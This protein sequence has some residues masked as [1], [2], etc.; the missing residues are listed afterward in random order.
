MRRNGDRRRLVAQHER[1]IVCIVAPENSHSLADSIGAQRTFQSGRH[2]WEKLLHNPVARAF[3]SWNGILQ[4]RGRKIDKL[5]LL[6]SWLV[7]QNAVGGR[8]T[9]RFAPVLMINRLSVISWLYRLN[10]WQMPYKLHI[11]PQYWW[12]LMRSTQVA[13]DWWKSI[14]SN[15]DA[16][17]SQNSEREAG[18]LRHE[19][20]KTENDWHS[21]YHARPKKRQR[22]FNYSARIPHRGFTYTIRNVC[23]NGNC[24]A[25]AEPASILM[26]VSVVLI[27]MV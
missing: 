9:R 26:Y 14:G 4:R 6:Y 23:V 16:N 12:I 8:K 7:H 15:D 13:A 5:L 24:A 22:S 3:P 20:K 10:V 21:W 18:S 17:G 27:R 11:I 19:A 2:E 1:S 25:S